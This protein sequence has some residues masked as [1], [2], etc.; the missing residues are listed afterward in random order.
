MERKLGVIR[1]WHQER[2]FGIVRVGPPSSLEKYF[3][4]VSAIQSGTATPEVGMTVEF[5]VSDK[6]AKENQLRQAVRADI[7]IPEEPAVEGGSNE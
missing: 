2:G 1:S 7:I 3:L 5:E 4:H 6:P